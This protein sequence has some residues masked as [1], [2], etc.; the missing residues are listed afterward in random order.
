[1]E[2]APH[3][4]PVTQGLPRP[5][6]PPRE[7]RGVS[8][9]G[10]FAMIAAIVLLGLSIALDAVNL[11]VL[12]EVVGESMGVGMDRVLA[13]DRW[14]RSVLLFLGS[15]LL[16]G[17]A[18]LAAFVAFSERSKTRESPEGAS[19]INPGLA[20]SMLSLVLLGIGFA[21]TLFAFASWP[22]EEFTHR[23]F[24][25]RPFN[26]YLT[27]VTYALVTRAVGSLTL[28]V[29]VALLVLRP[30]RNRSPPVPG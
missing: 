11:L 20:V 21:L 22:A 4:L 15:F 5:P 2:I 28:L 7:E 14:N 17:A 8:R 24:D 12:R 13:D 25:S 3:E 6:D 1:M 30:G 26:P 16:L 19:R 27:L 9:V 23:Y 29:G 10:L 18:L